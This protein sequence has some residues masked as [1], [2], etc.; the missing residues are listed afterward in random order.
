M[1][2]LSPFPFRSTNI[3]FKTV[4]FLLGWHFPNMNSGSQYLM[5]WIAQ[6]FVGTE[7]V[8]IWNMLSLNHMVQM[9]KEKNVPF[10]I[11]VLDISYI[12]AF[13]KYSSS[14]TISR[15]RIYMD[16]FIISVRYIPF[17]STKLNPAHVNSEQGISFTQI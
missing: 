13:N 17:S 8:S 5:V 10:R 14:I 15:V 16:I 12:T 2:H 6:T 1:H 11:I 4:T 7:N 9:R 3:L